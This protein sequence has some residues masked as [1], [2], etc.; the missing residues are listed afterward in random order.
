MSPRRAA[1]RVMRATQRRFARWMGR[2][3]VTLSLARPIVSFTFDDFPRSALLTAGRL[4]RERGLA[5]TYYTSMGLAGRTTSTGEMFQLRDLESLIQ[6]GHELGCHTYA[7][8]PSWETS[9]DTFEADVRKNAAALLD[10][11]PAGTFGTHSYP[12]SYPRPMTKR[13]MARY[14][15]CCRGGGQTFNIGTVDINYLSA[16][17]LEQA[18]GKHAAVENVVQGTCAATGWLILATHDVDNHPTR[19]GCTPEFF[20]N[21]V[22]AVVRSGA[23]VMP[24]LAAFEAATLGRHSKRFNCN[25]TH[26][27]DEKVFD[28]QG[29][30][31]AVNGTVR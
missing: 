8:C 3:P 2:R 12:I 15:A 4:L 22:D 5:G 29:G 24:V 1:G 26:E 13:R 21:V 30:S 19:F 9:S 27:R 18:N 28:D 11:L 17:F 31:S 10:H 7:H 16:Y 20:E 25:D 23:V 6:Q 14:F